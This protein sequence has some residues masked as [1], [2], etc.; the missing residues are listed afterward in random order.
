MKRFD[1][2]DVLSL[3]AMVATAIFSYAKAPLL[4]ERVAIHFDLYGQPNGWAPPAL[5]AWGLPAFTL[6]LWAIVR[7]SPYLVR[8]ERRTAALAAPISA[9]ALLTVVFTGLVH[10]LL[11][12]HALGAAFSMLGALACLMG[13]MF[14]GLGLLMLGTRPNPLVGIRT[15]WTL[16]SEENWARTH[17][18]A[19]AMFVLAGLAAIASPLA[20]APATF[21]VLLSGVMVA[22]IVPTVYSYVLARR[23]V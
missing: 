22:T 12:E 13:G 11:I 23:G 2:K 3:L 10:V 6:A 9:V 1:D 14:I 21:L 5:A 18:L 8:G 7:A 20:G 4:P 17:R 19:A 15:K 16:G